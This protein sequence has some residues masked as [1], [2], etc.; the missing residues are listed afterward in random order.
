M[1]FVLPKSPCTYIT[2][3]EEF[4]SIDLKQKRK[5]IGIVAICPCQSN[6]LPC[7]MHKEIKTG[8]RSCPFIGMLLFSASGSES[9]FTP[10]C[11]E[12]NLGIISEGTSTV[13]LV[14]TGGF[15]LEGVL[16]GAEYVSGISPS[17]T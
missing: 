13:L 16:S 10:S 5:E 6:L 4:V 14:T 1:I 15:G 11:S 17:G 7:R 8:A 9:V 2:F 12:S 3:L